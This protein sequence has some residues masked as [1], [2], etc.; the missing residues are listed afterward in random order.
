MMGR[1]ERRAA[2]RQQRRDEEW[3]RHSAYARAIVKEHEMKQAAIARIQK[4]GITLKDLETNYQKGY[5]DALAWASEY[6]QP[7]F[8]SAI[9]IYLKRDLK[10]GEMRIERMMDAVKQLLIEE[11]CTGDILERAKRETGM[12]IKKWCDT[13]EVV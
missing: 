1:T 5:H 2:E 4:N 6:Y 10:F 9:A 3:D 7:F 12:D 13:V 11:L 8:Y